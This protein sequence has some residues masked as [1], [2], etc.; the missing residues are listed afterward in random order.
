MSHPTLVLSPTN[1]EWLILL[2]KLTV[3]ATTG[4]AQKAQK[5]VHWKRRPCKIPALNAMKH[6]KTS[7][8]LHKKQTQRNQLYILLALHT[9]VCFSFF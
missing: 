6:L 2:I 3:A 1:R 8:S 9:K 4:Q 5:S 7:F